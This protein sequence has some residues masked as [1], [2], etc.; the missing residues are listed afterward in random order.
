MDLVL[1]PPNKSVIHSCRTSIRWDDKH[2]ANGDKN[3]CRIITEHGSKAIN[4]R[5]IIY[6]KTE[7][8]YPAQLY[9]GYKPLSVGH[10]KKTITNSENLFL[11]VIY[12]HVSTTWRRSCYQTMN[13]ILIFYEIS[14]NPKYY[15]YFTMLIRITEI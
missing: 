12:F 11:N 1:F 10:R 13:K 9:T 4:Q 6:F 14:T 8:L 5:K 15:L 2:I 3:G 7:S